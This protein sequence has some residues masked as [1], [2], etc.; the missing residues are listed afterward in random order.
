VFRRVMGVSAVVIAAGLAVAGCSPIQ[1]GA[2]AIVGSQRITLANLDT[3]AGLLAAAIRANP[4]PEGT[5][6]Q[7]QMTQDTL[8][9]LINFRVSDQVASQNGIT[10][11]TTQQQGAINDLLADY[12]E[13]A[14]ENGEPASSVNIGVIMSANGIAPNLKTQL[15][16]WLAIETAYVKAANGGTEPTSQAAATAAVDKYDHATCVAA[17]SLNIQVNPQFGRLDY[18]SVPYTVVAAANTVSKPA[19][20]SSAASTSGLSPAC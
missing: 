13:A 1:M 9:W 7:Q 11:S 12:V 5:L 19:G 3:E 18:S 10:V 17:K 6:T 15:G 20:T 4:P 2:A 16:S 8:A 14:E